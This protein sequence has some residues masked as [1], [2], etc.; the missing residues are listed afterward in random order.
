MTSEENDDEDE[1]K[2]LPSRLHLPPDVVIAVQ[3]DKPL[4]STIIGGEE[5]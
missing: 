4:A 2:T 3:F 5:G 1:I